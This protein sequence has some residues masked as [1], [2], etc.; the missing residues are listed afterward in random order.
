M[1][2]NQS[3][4]LLMETL[5]SL[6]NIMRE[7]LLM[8]PFEEEEK[9]VYLTD[10]INREMKTNATREKLE[11]KYNAAVKAKESEVKI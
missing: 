6:E 9:K 10:V 7:K 5:S 4:T 2:R 11:I 3:H 1:S 8:T